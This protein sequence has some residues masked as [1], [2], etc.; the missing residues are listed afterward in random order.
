LSNLPMSNRDRLVVSNFFNEPKKVTWPRPVGDSLICE[1]EE[2]KDLKEMICPR[3]SPGRH[4]N[5]IWGNRV[6]GL[7]RKEN[8]GA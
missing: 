8:P 3:S 6:I 7:Q 4:N 2:A 1:T 5:Q